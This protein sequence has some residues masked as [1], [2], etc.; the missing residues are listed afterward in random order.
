[1]V[2]TGSIL[3]DVRDNTKTR[4]E[5]IM[6]YGAVGDDNTTP[7]STDTTLGNETFRDSIDEFDSSATAT[8]VASLRILTTENN[9]E[10]MREAGWFDDPAA[11][12]M[13]TRNTFTAISKTADIQFFVDTSIEIVVTGT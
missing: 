8:I 10:T 1:M 5:T 4:L 9:G 3:A 7:V 2:L 6:T 11:G 13:W 12:T